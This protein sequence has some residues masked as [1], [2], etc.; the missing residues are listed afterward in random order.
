MKT[1]LV[2]VGLG[3]WSGWLG[4]LIGLL[5]LVGLGRLSWVGEGTWGDNFH[6]DVKF[7]R[8]GAKTLT[9][10]WELCKS[11]TKTLTT[12]WEWRMS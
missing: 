11:A 1:G 8:F 4:W 6:A 3:D 5:G 2:V 7:I 10:A 12:A 9:S